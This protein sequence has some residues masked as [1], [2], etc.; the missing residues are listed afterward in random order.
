VPAP[1][2]VD[3]W[4]KWFQKHPNLTTEEPVPVTVGGVSGVRIDALVSSEP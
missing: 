3:G 1:K 4:V 2:S